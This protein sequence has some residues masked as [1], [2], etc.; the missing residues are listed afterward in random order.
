MQ[1]RI[2]SILLVLFACDGVF[3]RNPVVSERE[4]ALIEKC[5]EQGFIIEWSEICRNDSSASGWDCTLDKKYTTAGD[6]E[7]CR[8]KDLSP[9]VDTVIRLADVIPLAEMDNLRYLT[10]YAE[11]ILPEALEFILQNVRY[12]ELTIEGY[13]FG[14]AEMK[15]LASHQKGVRVLSFEAGKKF[16]QDGVEILKK[17]SCLQ[18]LEITFVEEILGK[19][20]IFSEWPLRKLNIFFDEGIVT[21]GQYPATKKHLPIEELPIS[22]VVEKC[23]QLEKLDIWGRPEDLLGLKISKLPQL[24]TLKIASSSYS[25]HQTTLISKFPI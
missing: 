6:G 10:L 12:D 1:L 23:I 16:S 2:F 19:H 20:F 17:I 22:I 15:I 13:V 9:Q 18:S 5:R 24:H 7:L 4:L 8:L 14:D 25:S 3:G 11:E 21:Y